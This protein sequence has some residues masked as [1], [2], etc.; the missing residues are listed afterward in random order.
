MSNKSS[1]LESRFLLN[2]KEFIVPPGGSLGLLA[3]GNVG[4]RAWRKA[5]LDW[6]KT[7]VHVKK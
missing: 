2:G 3:L 7:Q 5:K 6:E 1:K 4:I